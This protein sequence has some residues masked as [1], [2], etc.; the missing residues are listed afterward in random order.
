MGPLHVTVD[1]LISGALPQFFPAHWLE[2]P[3]MA[4]TPFP[5]RIRIGYVRRQEAAYSYIM[6]DELAALG[7][8]RP[9]LHAAAL[10]NLEKL[11][12]ASITI[13]KV[14]GGAEGWIAATEDNFAAVR[15]L[16]PE[17]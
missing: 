13:G 6:E 11:P 15:I 1:Q 14:P 4:F 5:S 12:S 2:R 7:L 17:V 3:G 8:P 10:K 9:D 16:L